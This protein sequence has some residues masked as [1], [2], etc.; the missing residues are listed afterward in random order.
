[1]NYEYCVAAPALCLQ[2]NG[3]Y[4]S[5]TW[6]DTLLT[7]QIQKINFFHIHHVGQHQP[8][9]YVCVL[10]AA[11]DCIGGSIRWHEIKDH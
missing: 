2:I 8:S 7:I 6:Y 11:D 5:F 4:R 9:L 3:Y 1:M 10:I